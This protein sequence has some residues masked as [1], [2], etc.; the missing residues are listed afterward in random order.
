MDL[1][2][3]VLTDRGSVSLREQATALHLPLSTAYRFASQLQRAGLISRAG[4]G[5]F[6]IG[7]ELLRLTASSPKMRLLADIARPHVRAL[8]QRLKL[9]V[10]L[11]FIEEDMVTYMVKE[12]GGG[13]ALFTR[14]GTQLEAYCSAIG[15]V[16]L[17]ALP[18]DELERYLSSGPFIPL[19]SQTIADPDALRRTLMRVRAEEFGIDAEEVI[20]NLRCVAVPIRDRHGDVVCAL[21]VSRQLDSGSRTRDSRLLKAMRDCAAAITAEL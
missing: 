9:T 8:A 20:E 7:F 17:A 15:K 3:R 6:T 5:T 11:G 19:T 16:L 10:H 21:S 1:L 4:R 14:A 13:P 12:H 2:V 18:D